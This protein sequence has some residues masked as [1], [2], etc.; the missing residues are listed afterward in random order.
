VAPLDGATMPTLR[1]QTTTKAHASTRE[2]HP[3]ARRGGCLCT[4]PWRGGRDVH[5]APSGDC[6]VLH[7]LQPQR[8]WVGGKPMDA[9][10]QCIAE[11]KVLRG[12]GTL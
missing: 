10:A 7:P 4:P 6:S 12:R 1:E 8:I 9:P 11:A 3:R 5:T 2:L